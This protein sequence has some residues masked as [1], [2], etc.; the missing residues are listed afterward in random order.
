MLS[1]ETYATPTSGGATSVGTGAPKPTVK[2]PPRPRRVVNAS[3]LSPY[4]AAAKAATRAQTTEPRLRQLVGVCVWAAVI[5]GVALI[6]GIRAVIG[7]ISATPP[8]WY[9]PWVIGVGL[10]G[11]ALTVAA[12]VTVNRRWAPFALLGAASVLVI[13]AINLTAHAF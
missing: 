2:A 9:Q 1:T 11:L 13:V 8:S 6:I 12:F 4:I 3:P 5:G 7:S 10:T